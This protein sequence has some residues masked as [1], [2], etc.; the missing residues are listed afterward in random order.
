MKL[1]RGKCQQISVNKAHPVYFWDG[2]PVPIANKAEYLGGMLNAKADPT[3]EVNRRIGVA[4]AFCRKLQEF[5]KKGAPSRRKRI[6]FY[7]ALVTSKL[8]YGLKTMPLTDEHLDKLNALFYKG[9]RQIMNFK[10]TFVDRGNTNEKLM[11]LVNK[12]LGRSEA[13]GKRLLTVGERIKND[14]IKLLGDIVRMPTNDPIRQVTLSGDDLNLPQTKRV[15][16]PRVNW[17]ILNMTRAWEMPELQSQANFGLDNFDYKNAEH[18]EYI[19]Q[20]AYA[21]LF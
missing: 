2:S 14:S 19:T 13:S 7:D 10:T 8:A 11:S 17:S 18:I 3:V 20:A 5:W 1:N 21:L 6:L 4:G 9:L 15:G 12:E 16:R